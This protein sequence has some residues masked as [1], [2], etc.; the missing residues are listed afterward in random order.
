MAWQAPV[1]KVR[2]VQVRPI[3]TIHVNPRAL[4]RQE[5]R[6]QVPRGGGGTRSSWRS[7]GPSARGGAADSGVAASPAGGKTNG[8]GGGGRDTSSRG[9]LV[10]KED[11]AIVVDSSAVGRVTGKN[12]TINFPPDDPSGRRQFVGVVKG[13]KPHGEGMLVWESGSRYKGS[14]KRGPFRARCAVRRSLPPRGAPA[15]HNHPRRCPC[16]RLERHGLLLLGQWH[17]VCGGVG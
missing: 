9:K 17:R 12:V 10:R 4:Q 14:F 15:G 3:K 16:R 11:G 1:L 13:G 5:R 2:H 8:Q 6:S 7:E